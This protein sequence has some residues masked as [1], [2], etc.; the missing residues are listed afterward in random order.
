MSPNNLIFA[1]LAIVDLAALITYMPR[2]WHEC[3]R[4]QR[5][6]V[7]EHRV[8]E[9]E[10]V[11]LH[12]WHIASIFH[13]ISIW[14]TVMLAVWRYI[15]IAHPLKERKWCDMK[16]T[17]NMIIA[18]YVVLPI[19]WIPAYFDFHVG[20]MVALLDGDGNL[21]SNQTS[22]IPT[23][24][25]KMQSRQLSKLLRSLHMSLYGVLLKIVPSV[26]LTVFS[27]K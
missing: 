20:P 10:M 17:R 21:T 9:W 16:T 27:Y 11:S 12:S 18:G 22:S 6:S 2:S 8:Y 13:G 26:V 24:I 4:L 25:S 3:L 1:N 15:A 19:I 7:K 23:T 14:L 5:Y